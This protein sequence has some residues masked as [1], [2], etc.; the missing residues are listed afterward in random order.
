MSVRE[1]YK[2]KNVLLSGGTGF[3]GKVLVEKL[4]RSCTDIGTIFII[5][6][7]K[8]GVNPSQR[9]ADFAKLPLFAP[10]LKQNPKALQ[11]LIAIEGDITEEDL[12]LK[13]EVKQKLQQNVNIIF[14]VA[15]SLKLEA[16]LK[17]AVDFNLKGT[18][19]ML[20]LALGIKNLEGVQHKTTVTS[21]GD[22]GHHL[23]QKI[24]YKL[25]LDSAPFYRYF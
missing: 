9:I 17:E 18:K 21:G 23:Q 7:S 20:E 22:S 5:C 2:G 24:P 11:K 12:G 25:W 13:P 14:H 16:G 6:R 3:M 10:L 8:R 1:W 4:L 19:R 15:A